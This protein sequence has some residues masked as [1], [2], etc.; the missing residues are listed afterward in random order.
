LDF[1]WAFGT[2]VDLCHLEFGKRSEE[3][4][5]VMTP[6]IPNPEKIEQLQTLTR[7]YSF[8]V[9]NAGGLAHIIAAVF[10][11]V[12]YFVTEVLQLET[13]PKLLVCMGM[14]LVWI[15][16]CNY[17]RQNLYQT[18]GIVKESK[19]PW[20]PKPDPKRKLKFAIFLVVWT[21]VGLIIPFVVFIQLESVTLEKILIFV[22]YLALSVGLGV[23]VAKSR[24]DMSLVAPFLGFISIGLN[25]L[26]FIF[27]SQN[28]Q[29]NLIYNLFAFAVFL[30]FLGVFEHIRYQRITKELLELQRSL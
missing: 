30:A 19:T 16:I 5:K 11:I 23:Y 25:D 29:G 1:Y 2:D 17:F 10:F 15:P 24:I 26:E 6:N 28:R 22:A 13:L 9:N 8:L 12:A 3:R 18:L 7:R 21:V 20:K 14:F 4:G 27:A